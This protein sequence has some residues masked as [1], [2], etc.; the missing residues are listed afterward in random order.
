MNDAVV[1]CKL[2][3]R[4][5]LRL[6]YRQRTVLQNRQWRKRGMPIL[7]LNYSILERKISFPT[8]LNS[9]DFFIATW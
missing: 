9:V 8:L 4:L 1:K 5:G 6:P 3:L 7:S 2:V